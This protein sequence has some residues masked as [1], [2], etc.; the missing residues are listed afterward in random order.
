MI[1]NKLHIIWVGDDTLRPDICIDTWRHHHTNW[2]VR[3][4]G[5]KELNEMVWINKNHMDQI[6]KR[7]WNG[8]ADMMRWE[9]LYNEGGVLVDAD[10]VCLRTL[11]PWMLDLSIFACWEN[12]IVRPGLIAAGYVGTE[13][14]NPLIGQIIKDIHND[15][16]AATG[17][18]WT[19]VGPQRLTDVWRKYK[20]NK[21]T[22]LPSHF[23]IPQHYT[24]VEYTGSGVVYAEQAWGSTFENYRDLQNRDLTNVCL[25]VVGPHDTTDRRK[26]A[27]KKKKPTRKKSSVQLSGVVLN[28]LD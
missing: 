20:Y 12:E 2:D 5:N 16:N 19:T 4:W 24:G 18:A 1:P 6:K 10:S 26:V 22:I 28:T 27:G 7:E 11:D 23:F 25:S 8:V 17:S 3:V 9:I 15:P 21:L 13:P 14:A